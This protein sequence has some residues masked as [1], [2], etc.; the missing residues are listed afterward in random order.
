M[1]S[2]TLV[3]AKKL[4]NNEIVSGVVQDIIDVNPLY[5]ALPFIGYEGQAIVVNRENA[6]GD[7]SVLAVDATITAKA[8]ATFTQ[9]TFSATKLIGDVEMDGL[10]QAQSASAGVDQLAIEISSKAK[11]VGRLFQSGMATGDGSTPNMNSLHSMVDSGQFTGTSAGQALTFELLDE[12][13]DLVLS[14][15]GD[16]DWIMMPRRTMRSYKVLLRALGGTTSDWVITLPDG[17][18][19]IGYEST[20][21]FSNSFL[22]VVETANGAALTTGALASVWM[23]NFDDG[24]Q[25]I[26]LAGIHPASV[27]AGIQVEAVGKTEGKDSNLMRIKQYANV[28]QFNRKGLSRLVSINN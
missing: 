2:Q 19:T 24:S 10:V 16:V 4:I 15:D 17:R 14:K 28:A 20:P 25:K 26:G 8:A 21:I 27:A 1:A 6:L 22:S 11:S 7:A 12:G 13:M 18:T 5:A 23:G 3:E 9:S